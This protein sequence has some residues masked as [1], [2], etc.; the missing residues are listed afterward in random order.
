[1]AEDGS[2]AS[3]ENNT[4]NDRDIENCAVREQDRF[5]PIANVIRIMRKVLPTHAKIFDDAKETIQEC[6]SEF[7]SFITSEVN[8][9]CQ[10]EQRNT[11]TAEDVLWA[12]NKLGLMIRWI[13]CLFTFRREQGEEYVAIGE[14]MPSTNFPLV[15][16]EKSGGYG[17]RSSSSGSSSSDSGTSSSDSDSGSSSGS[18]S[19][20]Y[21]AD[22]PCA[23]SKAS[24]RGR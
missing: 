18:E 13:L 22:S 9:H 8:D 10:K 15:V 16:T 24:P 1:M 5:M 2:L 14:E 17:R 3:Q 23:G 20:A 4:S 21:A 12:M 6:V 11:I 19:G 7:I